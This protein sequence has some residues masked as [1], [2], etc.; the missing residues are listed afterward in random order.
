MI[1]TVF[2]ENYDER[3]ESSYLP[4]DFPTEE[5]AIEYGESLDCDYKIESTKGECV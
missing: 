5:E 3:Y 2:P 1:Y 4:Q